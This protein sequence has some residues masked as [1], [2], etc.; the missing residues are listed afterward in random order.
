MVVAAVSAWTAAFL[1]NLNTNFLTVV[2]LLQ[3][4]WN[5]PCSAYF[6]KIINFLFHNLRIDQGKILLK[7]FFW[8]NT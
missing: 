4:S 8:Q 7:N 5:E 1:F 2:F 3:N 6:Q